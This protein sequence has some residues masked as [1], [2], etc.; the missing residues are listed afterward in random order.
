MHFCVLQEERILHE[1]LGGK[2][3]KFAFK[4]VFSQVR[5]HCGVGGTEPSST[6]CLMRYHQ[7]L[8]TFRAST[9]L[10]SENP[11]FSKSLDEEK[12]FLSCFGCISVCSI[13]ILGEICAT[14]KSSKP[15]NSN[16]SLCLTTEPTW[17]GLSL[18]QQ[19]NIVFVVLSSH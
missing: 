12:P 2:R 5:S 13:T 15:H 6:R 10:T 17:D 7:S 18:L 9:K 19:H 14:S 16:K 4:G 3:V 11:D 1:Y 8:G